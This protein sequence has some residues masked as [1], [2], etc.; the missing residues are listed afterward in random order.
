MR[1]CF[2]PNKNHF[3]GKKNLRQNVI[4]ITINVKFMPELGLK[5]KTVIRVTDGVVSR[6]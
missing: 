4:S 6:I 5:I 1:I 2:D 3:Y